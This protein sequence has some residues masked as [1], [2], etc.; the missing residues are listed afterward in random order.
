MAGVSGAAASGRAAASVT[1]RATFGAFR[2]RT[3]ARRPW[4]RRKATGASELE[5]AME[6]SEVLAEMDDED[7]RVLEALW[8]QRRS[9]RLMLAGKY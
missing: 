9:R 3:T 6:Y 2:R 7:D 5:L 1:L 4:R 8:A